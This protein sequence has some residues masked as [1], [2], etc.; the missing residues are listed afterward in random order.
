MKRWFYER[1]LPMWAKQTLLKELRLLR[2]EN[3]RLC[4]TLREQEA[5]IKGLHKGLGRERILRRAATL[6]AQNDKENE[7][8]K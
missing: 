6:L 8:A 5:Y 2:R 3:A 4:R 7:K 1:F